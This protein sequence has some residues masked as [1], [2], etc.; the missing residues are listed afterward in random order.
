MYL[1]L[2]QDLKLLIPQ[3]KIHSQNGKTYIWDPIRMKNIILTPEEIVRQ[4][5]LCFLVQNVG[6]RTTQIQ[7]EKTLR[8]GAVRK[9]FDIVIYFDNVKPWMI[10]E[11]KRPDMNI[12]QNVMDQATM[13]NM[14]LRAPYLLI[15]NGDVHLCASIQENGTITYLSTFPKK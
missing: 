2:L 4:V 12:N 6:I 15:S 5:W 3:V 14:S 1:N 7:V 9:R 10:I 11:C 13:Y 8:I